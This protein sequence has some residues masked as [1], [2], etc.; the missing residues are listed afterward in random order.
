MTGNAAPDHGASPNSPAPETWTVGKILDWTTQHLKKHGSDTPRLDAELLLA[1]CRACPRIQLYVQFSEPVTEAQRSQMR[2]LV[3][4]RAAHEPVAYLIGYREFFSLKFEVTRDVLIPRPDTETLVVEALK[5]LQEL[6][7]PRLLDIGTGSGCIAIT[8]AKQVAKAE[9]V[10]IDLSPAALAIA[11][12][13][14]KS[15]GVDARLTF[16]EGNLVDSLPAGS[17]FDVIA[18]NLPYI[19]DEEMDGLDPDVRLHE[20]HLALRGGP[21]GLSLIARLIPLAIPF[22]APE[23]WLLLEIDPH[24]GP[25]VTGLLQEQGYRHIRSAKD[26]A[27]DLRVLLAQRPLTP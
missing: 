9:V 25:A 20:P 12:K 19:A 13:N 6:P 17:L 1:H 16:L 23:G 22:L 5:L 24:Q 21:K 8:F 2:D 27:G 11:R 4:R 3:K 14:A 15:N 18:A 7:A 10:A 26:T